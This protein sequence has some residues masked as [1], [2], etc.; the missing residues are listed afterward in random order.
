MFEAYIKEQKERVKCSFYAGLLCQKVEEKFES[1]LKTLTALITGSSAKRLIANEVSEDNP[2]AAMMPDIITSEQRKKAEKTI[3]QKIQAGTLSLPEP[4]LEILTIR[5]KNVTDAFLEM[6][7]RMEK[8]KEEISSAL[9]GGKTY[10]KITD[11]ELSAGDTHNHGRSVV[12]L[13]TDTGKLVYKPHNMKGDAYIYS[14]AERFFPEFVGIPKVIAF[15]DRFGVC[16]FIEKQRSEGEEEARSFWYNMGG[17]TAF[18]KILGSTDMHLENITC[19]GGKP[20]ILDLETILS[21]IKSNHN[22][23]KRFPQLTEIL[24]HSPYYT[25]ILPGKLKEV[26][27]SP[28]MSTDEKGLAPIVNGEKEPVFHYLD[29]FHAGYHAAYQQTLNRR[30]ELAAAL[31]NAPADM[32][33]RIIVYG[34][35]EYFDI[36]MRLYNHDSLA[37][38]EN[39]QKSRDIL[40]KLL[41]K[42]L[43]PDLKECVASELEQIERGD[44]PYFYT[45]A[46]SRSI[47]SDGMEIKKDAFEKSATEHALENL[48][49]MGNTDELFDKNLL[50]RAIR[51][52]P[53]KILKREEPPKKTPS[54]TAEPLSKEV[55]LSEA[56]ELLKEMYSLNIPSPNG[57]LLWGYSN[58]DAIGFSFCD[59][60]LFN[61]LAGL[62]AFSSALFHATGDAEAKKISEV[63]TENFTDSLQNFYEYHKSYDF[64]FD[65]APQLGEADGIAGIITA[66]SLLKIIFI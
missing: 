41:L 63:I 27:I 14:L 37:T 56:E 64:A 62:A 49:A 9:L 31:R 48:Y 11:I 12:I 40:S 52:Y 6:L 65:Y 35:Q 28:F 24:P 46:K 18:L 44:I 1:S 39:Y 22:T 55:A 4:L 38:T 7:C 23:K 54:R 53:S 33:I 61:G 2:Y 43:L 19:H 3:Q 50:D 13:H 26:E 21:P 58:D 30:E 66:L 57:S 8:H 29:S 25:A 45:T 60:D 15:A 59:V 10:T 32:P 17:T 42:H 47:F 5:L 34:T 20:Y 36:I 51:Q 16:E